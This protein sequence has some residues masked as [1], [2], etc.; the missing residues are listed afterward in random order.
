M[1]RIYANIFKRRGDFLKK[2]ANNTK[3]KIIS[4]LDFDNSLSDADLGRTL[5]MSRQAIHQHT[6]NMNIRNRTAHNLCIGCQKRIRSRY[7]LKLCPPCRKLSF[8]HEF[9]CG[10]CGKVNELFGSKAYFRRYNKLAKRS[11]V[12]YCNR[13]C[14]NTIRALEREVRKCRWYKKK[15]RKK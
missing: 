11:K 10:Y 12:E 8:G 15:G 13:D 4:L 1:I 9:V 6:R 5:G 14:Y 7:K 2:K 3:A